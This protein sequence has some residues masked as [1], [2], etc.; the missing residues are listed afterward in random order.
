MSRLGPLSQRFRA[1]GV[2][3]ILALQ[4]CLAAAAVGANNITGTVRNQSRGQPAVGDE[5]ILLRLD[6]GMREARARTDGHGAFVIPV[7]N[8]GK[9]YLVRV[10]HQE[11]SYEQRASGGDTLSINVFDAA[12]HVRGV[13]GS[14]EILR[15]G[16]DGNRLQISDLYEVK[17]ES[18]PPLTKTGKS[19]FEVYLPVGAK[20][21][22]VLAAGPDKT[23]VMISA[24]PV[25]NEPG[26]YAVSFP[27]RPG[28]TKF[29]FNCDLPY[30]GHATFQPRHAYPVQQMAVMIPPTM[31][32]SSRSTAFQIL[33]TGNSNYQVQAANHLEPGEGPGFE[34]SG[35]G[36]LPPLRA[37]A[38][39]LARS[40]SKAVP[41]P[42]LS[43]PGPSAAKYSA[44]IDSRIEQAQSRSQSFIMTGLATV[45]LAA[46]ALLVWRGRKTR[47]IPAAKTTAPRTRQR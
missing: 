3:F 29:A 16:T 11:V 4:V 15:A 30:D 37:E 6:D 14:I 24:A 10:L 45:F 28:A 42:T 23:A 41:S 1:R 22:S 47:S 36:T 25:P 7:R 20:I 26:H 46:C 9:P 35:T 17:N 8:P 5:V 21:D 2:L 13:S 38:K 44:H 43:V 32:F 27:L 12:P 31:K 19:T 18:S 33:A 40:Q 34:V 39:P